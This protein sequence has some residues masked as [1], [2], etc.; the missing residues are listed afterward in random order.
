MQPL[1]TY[2]PEN[3]NSAARNFPC[4]RAS[5][6]SACRE[7]RLNRMPHQQRLTWMDLRPAGRKTALAFRAALVLA[8]FPNLESEAT[9]LMFKL[10]IFFPTLC[11][12]TLSQWIVLVSQDRELRK[13]SDRLYKEAEDREDCFGSCHSTG[14]SALTAGEWLIM[15]A[16]QRLFFW[17]KNRTPAIQDMQLRLSNFTSPRIDRL[18]G[19]IKS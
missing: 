11:L 4:L 10:A 6:S 9:V 19:M 18:F 8:E 5:F 7:P 17:V 1:A 14:R 2:S 12:L 16:I 13:R 3:P 15:I